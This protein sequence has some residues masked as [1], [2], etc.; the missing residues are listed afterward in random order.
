MDALEMKFE[1]NSFD[2]V[3]A[4]ES[5]EH[6]PDKKQYVEEMTRVLKPGGTIVIA[7]WCQREEGDRCVQS[8]HAAQV[9]SDAHVCAHIPG[10]ACHIRRGRLGLLQYVYS[11]TF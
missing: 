1:D 10:N 5:G 4:C 9:Y 8:L 2:M 3:W 11:C 7:C 6:M